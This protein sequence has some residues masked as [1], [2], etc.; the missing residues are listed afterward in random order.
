MHLQAQAAGA[1][2]PAPTWQPQLRA[3]SL[4]GD[5]MSRPLPSEQQLPRA[6]IDFYSAL[7]PPNILPPHPLPPHT[8]RPHPHPLLPHLVCSEAKANQ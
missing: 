8:P 6:T 4:N 1:F 2:P 5:V 3:P 7:W